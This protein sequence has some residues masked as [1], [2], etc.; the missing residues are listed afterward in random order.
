[1]ARASGLSARVVASS[2]GE[3][4]YVLRRN[5]TAIRL[6]YEDDLKGPV[7]SVDPAGNR[8]AGG[9]ADRQVARR[10][11]SAR[12]RLEELEEDGVSKPPALLGFDAPLT[13]RLN[14]RVVGR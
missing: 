11:R 2:A 1:M 4:G 14:Q 12:Q 3:V 7:S 8:Y 6:D 10:I 9:R 5:G 13:R